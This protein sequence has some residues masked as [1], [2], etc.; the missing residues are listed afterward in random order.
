LREIKNAIDNYIFKY[1]RG[2]VAADFIA[3]GDAD[4]KKLA[5]EYL[6][7]TPMPENAALLMPLTQDPDAGV[8]QAAEEAM[9]E[10]ED[11]RQMPCQE[12]I[13]LESTYTAPV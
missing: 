8:K 2:N 9:K 4:L 6:R 7:E 5:I 3:S 13:S 10:L 11:V 1:D 12:L